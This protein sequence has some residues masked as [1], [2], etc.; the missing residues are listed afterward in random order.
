MTG[1]DPILAYLPPEDGHVFAVLDGARVD[2]LPEWLAQQGIMRRA[3]YLDLKRAVGNPSGPW[4]VPCPDDSV[5]ADIRIGVPPEAA[6]WWQWPA[7]T[8]EDARAAIYHHLRGLG[9]VEIP[10]AP[11]G[12]TER[13]GPQVEQVLFR[14]ADPA[15][16]RAVL[17]LLDPRQRMRLWGSARA[18]V[19]DLGPHGGIRRAVVPSDMPPRAPGLLRLTP[20]QVA[21]LEA[22]QSDLRTAA[23]VAYMR[24]HAALETS[25]QTD[26]ELFQM[27]RAADSR[28]GRLGLSDGPPRLMFAWLAAITG[29]EAILAPQIEAA[30]T[31][32]GLYPDAAL[33]AL[34]L[35]LD[36]PDVMAGGAR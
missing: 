5:I 9:M 33:D 21:A 29:G 28:A 11:P 15:I 22:R 8:M 24:E 20:D 10:I 36:D 27:A 13:I 6:V 30:I 25:D 1:P 26:E 16:M 31:R 34:L 23:I 12:R 7:D 18:I 14:H 4:L 3:L 17:P 19:V 35:A 2:G 32:S